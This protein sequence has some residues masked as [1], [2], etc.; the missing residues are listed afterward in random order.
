MP[1]GI[2]EGIHAVADIAAHARAGAGGVSL[3]LIKL[4]GITTA[5]D[6][7]K[8]CQRLGLKINVAAKIAESSVA[9]AAAIHLACAVPNIDWGVS[10]THFY[11]AEDIVR[12]PLRLRAGTVSLPDGPGLGVEIDE[13]AVARF[14]VE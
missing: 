7:A 13:A 12:Q 5:L 11:L 9:S 4:G 8:L 3:K 14:K 6:A 10:L 1:I 2:D